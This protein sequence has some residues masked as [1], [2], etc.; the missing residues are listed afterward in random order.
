MKL[1]DTHSHIFLSE[2]DKDRHEVIQ[3]AKDQGIEHI[4]L[5]N[6]D[7]STLQPLLEICDT[8]NDFCLP[9][10][11]LHPTSVKADYEDEL[12]IV[13]IW[14]SR[15][16]FYGIG[17]T[18]ID[19]Y[20]DKTHIN[21]QKIAFTQQIAFSKKMQLPI[22]IHARES[23]DEIFEVLDQHSNQELTGIFHSFTGTIEQA[24]KAIAMGFKIGVG[25]LLTFSN[26]GIDKIVQQIGIE[27]IVVE[28]D[29]PYLAP[30]PKRGRRNES[31]YL[32]YIIEKLAEIKNISAET[33]AEVT[34]A[35]AKKLF[36]I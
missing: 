18:G 30:I 21:E 13:E 9:V 1:I 5:P 32:I 29:S 31:S 6:V 8:Y 22:I 36:N 14:L 15:K 24:R 11:G 3:R 7:S 16:K 35:N 26:T 20:W 19:L 33:V 12:K 4:I 27:E 2:F 28:T 25:G 17:E 34:T 10:I 23:F